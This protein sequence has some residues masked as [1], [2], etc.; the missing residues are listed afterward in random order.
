MALECGA[1]GVIIEVPI[2]YPKITK[3]FGWTWEDVFKKSRDVINYARENGLHTVFF[4]YDTT[5]A[6]SSDLENLCKGVMNDPLVML[7]TLPALTGRV[8]EVVLGKKSG[9]ASIIYKMGEL[10]MG[11]ASDAQISEMLTLV[12]QAG[13]EKR[14]FLSESEFRAIADK[15]RPT[16]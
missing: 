6:R 9:K 16:V 4:P 13:I 12:K 15:V 11:E 10:G 1:H 14:D 2:G 3:Q 7:G 8:G 5:R